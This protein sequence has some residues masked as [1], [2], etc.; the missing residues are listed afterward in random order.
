MKILIATDTYYPSVNGASYFTQRLATMLAKRGYEV[1]VF[2]PGRSLKDTI[3]V[4]DGVTVYGIR[5]IGIPIHPHFRVSPLFLARKTIKKFVQEI[6]P[7]II[8]IQNHFMI[9]KGAAMAAQELNIPIMGTNHFMPENLVHYFHLPEFVEKRLKK[10]GWHQF[11]QVYKYLDAIATPT[12]TAARLIENLGLGKE[13]VPVSCGIDLERFSPKNNGEYL[14][15]RYNI[16]KDH[17]ILLYVGR[18]DKEKR[19]ELIIRALPQIIK[20]VD[21]HLVLAGIGKLRIPLE[22]M[23]QEMGIRDRITFTGFVPDKDLPNL[24]RVADLFVIAGIAE[25]QSIVTMEAL[26]SGLPAV[27][28]NAMALPELVHD[29]ENGYLFADGDSQ[30]LAGQAVKIL[31]D[32]KLR[33]QMAQKS[34]QII[35]AHDINKTL[36]K[37][38]LLYRQT[39]AQHAFAPQSHQLAT[40]KRWVWAWRQLAKP[41]V[42]S[43]LGVMCA[44]VSVFFAIDYKKTGSFKDSSKHLAMEVYKEIFTEEDHGGLH[45]FEHYRRENFRNR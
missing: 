24:Y 37:Y 30:M 32:S 19:I 38:E 16:P 11:A 3:S 34:L 40:S 12:K 43:G 25:L 7:D 42:I 13:I 17:S 45:H 14:K 39:I 21:A 9:G 6:G 44:V 31:S 18:L 1:F 8:H 35:Q 10:F 15:E 27:A 23:A 41:V 22:V 29:G 20:N 26:A 2:A 33:E 5:S 28:V 4:H 36:D